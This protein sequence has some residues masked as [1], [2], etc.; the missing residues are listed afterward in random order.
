[1]FV[2]V[3]LDPPTYCP[4]EGGMMWGD[5][6]AIRG[7][8]QGDIMSPIIINIV[9]DIVVIPEEV[10][11]TKVSSYWIGYIVGFWCIFNI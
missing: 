9:V 2:L 11:N 8:T 1:M 3:I 10:L 6:T 7:V 4:K 5:L